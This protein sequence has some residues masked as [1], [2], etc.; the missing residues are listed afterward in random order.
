[1]KEI[2]RAN[3]DKLIK[4]GIIRNSDRGYVDTKKTEYDGA[5]FKVG[6][7]RTVNGRHSYI[8][9][10]YADRAARLG[11]NQVK[12]RKFKENDGN[13]KSKRYAQKKY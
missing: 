3:L 12:N 1:M 2:S 6:F 9:D 11:A 4:A 5:P 8:Q 13:G 7:Y 10:E